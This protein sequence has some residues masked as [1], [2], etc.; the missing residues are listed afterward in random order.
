[1]TW[2]LQFEY[3]SSIKM[4]MERWK[5]WLSFL[6]ATAL[7]VGGDGSDCRVIMRHV[8]GHVPGAMILNPNFKNFDDAVDPGEGTRLG[9]VAGLTGG[10]A[11]HR[12]SW[13]PAVLGVQNRVLPLGSELT[14]PHH[15][16]EVVGEDEEEK[17]ENKVAA[18]ASSFG[19][20]AK[21]AVIRGIRGGFD[22]SERVFD[23]QE[24]HQQSLGVQ[25]A[26]MTGTIHSHGTRS[27]MNR[28]GGTQAPRDPCTYE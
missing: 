9:N 26:P 25:M 13:E 28:D 18:A 23:D 15:G 24:S 20:R 2:D 21:C 19:T 11:C 4:M 7:A 17:E 1:V 14:V 27:W 10:G 6:S 12:G 3:F 22:P 5:I 8:R 16:W